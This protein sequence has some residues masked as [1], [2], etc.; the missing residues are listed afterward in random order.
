MSS[1]QLIGLVFD[2]PEEPWVAEIRRLREAYDPARRQFPVEITVAGSSGLGWFS[3][4]QSAEHIATQV[5]AIAQRHESF[6]CVFSRVEVFEGSY[7]YF[8]VVADETPFN[9]FQQA[10]AS[11]PLQFESSHFSYKPHCTIVELSEYSPAAAKTALAIF[12]V[13]RHEVM[14]SSVSLY[15]VEVATRVCSFLSSYA[16]GT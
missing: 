8:L 12:P 5:R 7:I 13:P 14:I 11:S 6:I 10:L 2:L 1:A 15:S 9:R 4:G 3:P 16:L